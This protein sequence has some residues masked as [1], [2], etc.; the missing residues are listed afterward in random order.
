MTDGLA[1]GTVIK[2]QMEKMLFRTVHYPIRRRIAVLLNCQAKVLEYGIELKIKRAV[3]RGRAA[4]LL[5]LSQ[6]KVER[7]GNFP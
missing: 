6:K 4:I 3:S 7:N 2:R 1:H 5:V